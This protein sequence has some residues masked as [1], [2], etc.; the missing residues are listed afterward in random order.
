MTAA[1]VNLLNT[2]WLARNQSRFNNSIISWQSAI[3]LIISNTA[4]SGNNTKKSSSNSI[5]DFSFLKLFG[6]SIHNPRAMVLKEI[7]WQPPVVSWI[8]CNIDGASSGNPG[9]ASCGGIFRDSDA[10]FLFAFAEPLG[11]ASSYFAEL[12]GA[13]RAIEIA[14]ANNWTNLWLESDSSLVVNAFKNP[15]KMVAWLLRNRW[16]NM[17]DMLSQMTCIVT[18][19]YREGNVVADLLAKFGLNAPSYTSWHSAPDFLTAALV[20]NKLGLPSFRICNA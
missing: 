11:M 13:L 15:N 5:R 6:I 7:I 12:S 18:H 8:K 16:V 9:I 3:S 17:L 1:I 4:L 19:V 20:G 14:F 10:E 2:I